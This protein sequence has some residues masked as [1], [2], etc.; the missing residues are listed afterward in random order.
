MRT[1]DLG[2]ERTRLGDLGPVI[3]RWA[4]LVGVVGLAA[5][6]AL[7]FLV[8]DGAQ[9]FFASYLVS[10]AYFLSLSLGALFF[11]MI[12]HLTR[13]G[14][15]VVIRRQAEMIAA[16]LGWL[17]VLFIPVL[18]GMGDL[19]PWTD[20]AG[21]AEDELLQ[22]KQPYLNVPFFLVRCV[23]YFGVWFLLSRYF[24]RRSLEQDET[25]DFMLTVRMERTS[26]PAMVAF[27]FTLTFASFDFLMA[28]D[29]KWFSTIYGVYYFSGGV[30]AVCAFLPVVTFLLQRAGL[31]RHAIT[32]EHYHDLGKLVF[33]FVVF[34]AYIAFSQYM[35]IWYA[36]VPEETTWY[37]LRQNEP[38]AVVSLTLLFGHFVIPF[39]ALISS[40][41]KRHKAVLV[42]AAIYM[43]VMHWIDIYWLVMPE[44]SPDSIPLSPFDLTTFLGVG[45]LYV[46]A[47]AN[48]MRNRSLLPRRD[49]RLGESL[50]FENV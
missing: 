6:V 41:P 16:N 18:V 19:Y 35:L 10:F 46:A 14:W 11:V 31:V 33:A 5:S 30:L 50:G 3:V 49:P 2:E 25:G 8:E 1:V 22:W 39:L 20:A 4:L 37:L 34:W 43:L 15:S 28:R 12:Q 42:G 17:A 32:I 45:G 24:L 29:P 48:R 40:F 47:I 36:N 13:A 7:A 26:A 44:S 21:V 23:V 27:A 38:W 9:R